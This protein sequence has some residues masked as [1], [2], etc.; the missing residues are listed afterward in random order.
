MEIRHMER[1]DVIDAIPSPANLQVK[2]TLTQ[3]IDV[4]VLDKE[5]ALFEDEKCG[6][7]IEISSL[8]TQEVQSL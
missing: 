1:L 6:L 5:I 7:A 4:N 2:S 3:Q 8:A